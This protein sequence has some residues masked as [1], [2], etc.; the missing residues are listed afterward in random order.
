MDQ[1]NRPRAALLAALCFLL[2][3]LAWAWTQEW[4]APDEPRYAQIAREAYESGSL[5]VLYLNGELYPDKPPLVYWIAG[6]FGSWTNWNEFAMRAP[7][8]LSL[9][10]CAWLCWR[11]ARR[12]G[13]SEAQLWAPLVF[14]TLAGT[15]A[16]GPRLQLDPALSFL[17]L[18]A[19]ERLSLGVAR[20]RIGGVDLAIAGLALG[21][22]ALVKGPV[23]WL[24][25]LLACLSLLFVA[26]GWRGLSWRPVWGWLVLLALM[27]APVA[28]W[29]FSA[30]AID[31][32]LRAPLLFGQHLGRVAEGT[33]HRGPP[34]DHLVDLSYLMLPWT[35][36]LV[37]ALVRAVRD[38]RQG[39]RDHEHAARIWLS[40][41]FLLTLLVFSIMPV[42]RAL[43]LMPIYPAAALLIG[44]EIALLADR[45]ALSRWIR[46][47]AALLLGLVGAAALALAPFHAELEGLRLGAALVG[48][49]LVG[50]AL[51]AWRAQHDLRAQSLRLALTLA[52]AVAV[53]ALSLVPSINR[54]KSARLLAEAVAERPEK[55]ARIP[56]V[57]IQPEGYRFYGRI[58]AVREPLEVAL[59]REG[60]QFLALVREPDFDKLAPA[61][62]ERLVVLERAQVGSRDILLLGAKEP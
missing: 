37:A 36:L 23:A 38:W 59:E 24:H 50:G 46:W 34:W 33:A 40:A 16:Y 3:L 11:M 44:A 14:L 22:A 62:R 9:A 43:Y 42:K 1:P 4:W 21:A 56:C 57:G 17:I 8:L 54:F 25:G 19:V 58:P 47:P 49:V 7:S 6:W 39:R 45:G 18:A 27:I 20:V 13:W 41:W 32:R 30:I 31:E 53:A 10:G 55:P 2:P 26:R 12:F 61:L 15:F 51:L 29:A 35:P 52:L 60:R 5:V 28:I 48:V